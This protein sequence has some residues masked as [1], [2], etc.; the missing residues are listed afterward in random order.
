MSLLLI[1]QNFDTY[2]NDNEKALQLCDGF[3][4]WIKSAFVQ[5]SLMLLE[6]AAGSRQFKRRQW[7]FRRSYGMLWWSGN[8]WVLPTNILYENLLIKSVKYCVWKW[9]V[10]LYRND[11]L[12]IFRNFSWPKI[13]KKKNTIVHLFKEKV[14][15]IATKASL[16]VVK[17]LDIQQDLINGSYGPYRKRNNNPMYIDINSNH[18]PSIKK[19]IPKPVS[20][21]ISKLPSNKEIFNNNIR[22]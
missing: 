8:G 14:L 15:L 6:L 17:F 12:G 10:G 11:G 1:F 18:P 22:T 20:K 4:K 2:V 16:N 21:R 13:E 5:H 9:N 3:L 19:Q 7:A